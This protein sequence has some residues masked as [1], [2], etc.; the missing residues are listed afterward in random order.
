MRCSNSLKWFAA[1]AALAIGTADLAAQSSGTLMGRITDESGVAV[2]GAQVVITNQVTG[3]QNGALSQSDGRY[4]VAG[5]RAGG[6]YLVDIRM[7]GFGRQAVDDVTI[8]GGQTMTLDFRLSQEAI[9]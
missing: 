4:N 2:S 6:P 5:L 8:E 3:A 7:I 9:A 1:L